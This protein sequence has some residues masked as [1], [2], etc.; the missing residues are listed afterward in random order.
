LQKTSQN[1][2]WQHWQRTYQNGVS[3][4]TIIRCQPRKQDGTNILRKKR[5]P[6]GS[7]TYNKNNCVDKHGKPVLRLRFAEGRD[8]AMVGRDSKLSDLASL[9]NSF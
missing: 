7:Q 5:E 9:K 6:S 4:G 3:E 8:I 1:N 2:N